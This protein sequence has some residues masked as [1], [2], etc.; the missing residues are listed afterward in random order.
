MILEIELSMRCWHGAG[1]P[2]EPEEFVRRL[3]PIRSG[4]ALVGD[5]EAWQTARIVIVHLDAESYA[6][7]DEPSAAFEQALNENL[8]EAAEWLSEL[9]AA[10]IRDIKKDFKMD[11][12][13][14]IALDQNQVG[15]EFP[16]RL[17]AELGRLDVTLD[18]NSY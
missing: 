17:L 2:I 8:L 1:I 4:G 10:K 13:V 5:G 18:I 16:A 14:D 12:L 6:R 11:V 3:Q 9:D 7:H 15:L